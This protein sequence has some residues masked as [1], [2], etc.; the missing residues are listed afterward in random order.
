MIGMLSVV[1]A[2][3]VGATAWFLSRTLARTSPA[4]TAEERQQ[5]SI[6]RD[7]L[8]VQLRELEIEGADRNVD[9]ATA[10]DE[11]TRIEAELAQVLRRLEELSSATAGAAASSAGAVS[12]RGWIAALV[13]MAIALPLVAGGLYYINSAPALRVIAGLGAQQGGGQVPPMVLEMVA[14]LENRLKENP[15]DAEG[16]SRLGRAYVVLGRSADAQNA[17]ERA[18][19]LTPDN[20]EALSGY[21][22]LLYSQDPSNTGEPAYGLYLRLSKLDPENRDALWFLGLAAYQKGDFRGSIRHWERLQ[23]GVPPSD[24]AAEQIRNV[25]AKAKEQLNE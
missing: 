13:V 16:W 12:R 6:V 22:W 25:I 5:L 24:P 11:H 17:Y 21:A 2:V 23:K 14:R 8:I 3:L 15:G 19:A 9:A 4:V 20:V 18:L 10:A 7:R 1:A